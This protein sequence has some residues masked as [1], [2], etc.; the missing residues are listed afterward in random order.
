MPSP[1]VLHTLSDTHREQLFAFYFDQWWCTQR[2]R[3]TVERALATS[4]VVVLCDDEGALAGFA[5]IVSDGA[6]YAWIGDVM[7]RPDLRGSGVGATL[8]DAVLAHPELGDVV[9]WEL[10]CVPDMDDFYARWGF[11]D[12]AP[13]HMLRRRA[14]AAPA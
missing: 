4:R 14:I 12:P 1:Q 5:R 6:L 3:A 11:T 2:D 10:D 7:V 13:S 8:V 9:T